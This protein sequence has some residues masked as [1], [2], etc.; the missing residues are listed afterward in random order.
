[1][2]SG[3][4]FPTACRIEDLEIADLIVAVNEAEHR[5]LLE[6]RFAGWQDRVTYWHVSDIDFV[7]ADEATGQIDSMVRDLISK[8]PYHGVIA[9]MAKSQR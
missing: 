7:Q 6:G 9:C 3:S 5:A 2:P 8:L 1:M 4:R